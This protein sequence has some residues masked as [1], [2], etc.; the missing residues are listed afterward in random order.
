MQF[1]IVCQVNEFNANGL[2][3]FDYDVHIAAGRGEVV[4][5]HRAEEPNGFVVKPADKLRLDSLQLFFCGTEMRHSNAG[6]AAP[7]FLLA[8]VRA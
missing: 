1:E 4:P 7:G 2:R 3:E 6:N 8:A 5:D